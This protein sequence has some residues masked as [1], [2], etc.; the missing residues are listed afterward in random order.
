MHSNGHART[1]NDPKFQAGGSLSTSS[2]LPVRGGSHARIHFDVA[3]PDQSALIVE[4]W[5]KKLLARELRPIPKGGESVKIKTHP[6][7]RRL[8]CSLHVDDRPVSNVHFSI[9]RGKKIKPVGR[10][11]IVVGAMKAGTTTLFM[12]LS[13]HPQLCTTMAEVPEI[14]FKKEINYF[15]S[16][17]RKGNAPLH[18]DW[19]FP[20]DPDRHAW[21]LDVSPNYA[22]LPKTRLVPR[23]IAMLGGEIKLAYILRDPVDRIE[24]QIAHGMR[25]GSKTVGLSHCTKVSRYARHLDRF[26]KHIPREDI[27]L[28]DFE[29][30]REAPDQVIH[31]VCDF[32]DIAP[33]DADSRVYNRGSLKYRLSAAE[34]SKIKSR[35]QPDV[36][37][38]VDEYGFEPARQWLD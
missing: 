2:D 12:N 1:P 37:R 30:L 18:Y 13:R 3:A 34:R 35:L 11:F 20:F 26:A 4:H 17:Y 10:Y 23:R 31:S 29:Q 38:L 28:L 36:E 9:V 8:S 33:I 14:S 24:S 19:R 32:L 15:Q 27:L 16:L 5:R 21:T 6:R 25:E 22:K 7:A